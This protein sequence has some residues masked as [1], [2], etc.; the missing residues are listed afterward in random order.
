MNDTTIARARRRR[1]HRAALVAP[2]AGLALVIAGCGGGQGG[3]ES[4]EEPTS[5]E[6]TEQ[7]QPEEPSD[8]ETTQESGPD[9]S[10]GGGADAGDDAGSG[11]AEVA[12]PGTEVAVG[13]PAVVHVQ[14]LEEGEEYYAVGVIETTVTEIVE[15]DPAIIEQFDEDDRADLEGM[16]PWYVKAEHEVL[17]FEGFD[18]ADL[19]PSLRTLDAQGNRLT[20]GISFGGNLD[21]DCDLQLFETVEVGATAS[22]C[23]VVFTDGEPPAQVVWEGD[24]KLDGSDGDNPYEEQPVVWTN[25][26]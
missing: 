23:D 14:Q 16:T 8:Q 21:E 7:E 22:T 13:E 2:L 9:A 18:K 25:A 5:V 20:V 26:G 17:S 6:R 24:D 19:T 11:S 4:T 1:G 12:P 3:T 10:D 15:G